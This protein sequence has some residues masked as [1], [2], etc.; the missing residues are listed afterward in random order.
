MN[1]PYTTHNKTAGDWHVRSGCRCMARGHRQ[2][3]WTKRMRGGFTVWFALSSLLLAGPVMVS[4][5]GEPLNKIRQTIDAVI[6]V[7]S[8]ASLKAPERSKERQAK[9]RQVVLQRFGFEEMAQ[10]AMGRHWRERTPAERKEF[11]ALFSDLLERSYINKIESLGGEDKRQVLYTKETID[12]DGY[13]KVYTEVVNQRDQNVAIEYRLVRRHGDWEVYDV[14]IEG[15]SLV[16]NYRTQFNKIISQES[17][18][19]LIKKLKLKI[20]QE[21]AATQ[22]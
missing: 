19:Y 5:A 6:A 21:E 4:E 22:S 7:L 13:A 3:R 2:P 11:V 15:V 18:N 14:V 1:T 16:N 10:R 20:E 17:Y 12:K 8:D 9:I